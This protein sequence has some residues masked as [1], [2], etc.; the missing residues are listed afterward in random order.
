MGA[1]NATYTFTAT[2]TVTSGKLNNIIDQTIMTDDA[3]FTGGTVEVAGGKLKVRSGSITSNELASSSVTGDA[4]ANGAVTPTKLS[5]AGPSWDNAGGV[6]TL[7]QRAVELG[8][9]ITSNAASS[10]DFHSSF[11]IIDNDARIIRESGANG[12]FTISNI[13][14]GSII[15]SASGGVTF[16]SANM[17]NPVGVAPI[18]GARAWCVFDATKN[19]SGVVSNTPSARLL[20]AKGNVS[21][22]VRNSLGN[23]TVNF[24]ADKPMPGSYAVIGGSYDTSTI[25][26]GFTYVTQSTSSFVISTENTSG[27]GQDFENNS[28]VVFG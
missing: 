28:L 25:V 19:T 8:N 3:V 27:G 21:S 10:I 23:F 24:E 12:T 6:F 26:N 4:I 20:I 11:P 2:D 13:G 14:T 7:S 16:G 18:Y 15:F 17:P 1:V 22:V 9:G 5:T